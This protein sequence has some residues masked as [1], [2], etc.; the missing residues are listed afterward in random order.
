MQFI[1]SLPQFMLSS[2]EQ[3]V[4]SLAEVLLQGLYSSTASTVRSIAFS[5]R[6]VLQLDAL[7]TICLVDPVRMTQV[8][9]FSRAFLFF[10]NT[11][12]CSPFLCLQVFCNLIQNAAKFT[13]ANGT[14]TI[15]TEN[16]EVALY[17]YRLSSVATW[18]QIP[19]AEYSFSSSES[20]LS[21]ISSHLRVSH[22]SDASVVYHLH[23]H[24][25]ACADG[26]LLFNAMPVSH[27]LLIT[28]LLGI[29]IAPDVIPKLFHPFSQGGTDITKFTVAWVRFA[30]G[31]IWF[32]PSL[33]C[34]SSIFLVRHGSR[35]AGGQILVSFLLCFAC[36]LSLSDRF[37][38][39]YWICNTEL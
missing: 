39:S 28:V 34:M 29:G 11:F 22:H 37:V 15:T 25:F 23:G 16:Q 9:R 24:R 35:I 31:H 2:E 10:E 38:D 12:L 8:R 19:T 32:L 36:P 7:Q 33:L 21:S 20:S 13:P 1:L 4:P 6:I 26:I 3:S 27:I 5:L 17:T 14:L 30:G 18:L